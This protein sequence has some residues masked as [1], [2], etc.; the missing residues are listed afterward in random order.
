[1]NGFPWLSLLI[2]AP[3]AG[4][5]LLALAPRLGAGASR[6]LALAFSASTLALGLGAL[7]GFD[8]SRPGFQLVERHAWIAA[9][10]IHYHLGLDGMSLLL[11]L[12]TAIVSPLALLASW[13]DPRAPRFYGILFLLLQ[14]SVLGVFLSLDFFPWFLFFPF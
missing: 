6:V 2:F 1:M 4:A 3:W 12:L 13:R 11:V 8:R 7:R 5:L 9:L 10:N 14:G